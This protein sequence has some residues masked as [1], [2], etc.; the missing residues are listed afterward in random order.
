M[1]FWLVILI[2][3]FVTSAGVMLAALAGVPAMI[4][5]LALVPL[6]GAAALVWAATMA[7][8]PAGF[9][10]AAM[11]GAILGTVLSKRQRQEQR[12]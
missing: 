4:A 10:A 2:A 11:L 8:V 12:A 7:S 6:L 3:P 9:F 5:A 1:S